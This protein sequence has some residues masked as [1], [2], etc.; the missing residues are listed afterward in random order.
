MI[1]VWALHSRHFKRTL[2]QQLILPV[3]AVATLAC[4]FAGHG[5]VLAAGLVAAATVAVGVTLSG[6]RVEGHD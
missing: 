3:S 1:T 6:R 2:A 4:T 5:A